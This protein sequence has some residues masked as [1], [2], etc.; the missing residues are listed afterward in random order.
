[1]RR[2]GWLSA[3]VGCGLSV[4]LVACGPAPT[5]NA[6][7]TTPSPV[8][9]TTTA[10]SSTPTPSSSVQVPSPTE[11]PTAPVLATVAELEQHLTSQ[12]HGLTA[13]I[14]APAPGAGTPDATITC[15]GSGPIQ[16]G[17]A[18]TCRWEPVLPADVDVWGCE[19]PPDG[20]CGG[21][22]WPDPHTMLVAVLDDSGRYT[23]T[24]LDNR[25]EAL[26][27]APGDYPEGTTSCATLATPPDGG[28]ARNGLV[29]PALLH[30]WMSLG[31]PDAMDT[32]GDGRPCE[33]TYPSEIVTAVLGSPLTPVRD[34]D[35]PPLTMDDV[36]THAQAHMTGYLRPLALSG[37]GGNQP[38]TT[39]ATMA[40]QV[41][42]PS[43]PNT[44]S[45]LLYL[46][47]LDDTGGYLIVHDTSW[48]SG[49]ACPGLDDYP[50]G[51]ACAE[52]AQPPPD[53]TTCS[54]GVQYGEVLYQWFTLGRP[55]DWD[56][57]GDGRPCEDTYPHSSGWPSADSLLHP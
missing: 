41:Y 49:G 29:Y 21:G 28:G 26:H 1:M 53:W 55:T 20:G 48:H 14:G 54:Q 51:S 2:Q 31:Q 3:A 39:G 35:E 45:W 52:L 8:P 6:G 12:S 42:S 25:E 47:V 36:R 44:T 16:G 24:L 18:I 27:A 33:D 56:T 11:T 13:F 4:L 37:A 30:H 57:D 19:N 38:A 7:S 34:P 9:T 22:Q 40:C 32:D 50:P 43:W 23:F 17:D 5:P 10:A 15:Q 46:V